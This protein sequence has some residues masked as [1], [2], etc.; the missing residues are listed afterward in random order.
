MPKKKSKDDIL[1][2]IDQDVK[3]QKIEMPSTEKMQEIGDLVSKMVDLETEVDDIQEKLKEKNKKLQELQFNKIPDL[4][5]EF[6]LSKLALLDGTKIEIKR[7]YAASITDANR[8]D[9]FAWLKKNKHDS[10][11]KH[12]IIAKL[13]KGEIKEAKEMLKLLKKQ[14]VTFVDKQGIHPQTLNSFVRE[15]IENGENFPQELFKVFPI[16]KAKVQ[17]ATF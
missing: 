6:G 5:D 8:K 17:A 9:C 1:D 2:M 3:K 16:R 12:E 11:I 10:L 14:G 7:S 15:Q 4:F 13:K